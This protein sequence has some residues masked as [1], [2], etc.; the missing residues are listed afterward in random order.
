MFKRIRNWFLKTFLASKIAGGRNFYQA[1]VLFSNETDYE[2]KK[3]MRLQAISV[4]D[5]DEANLIGSTIDMNGDVHYPVIDFDIPVRLVPSSTPGHN[6]LY[7]DHPVTLQ[8]MVNMLA[9]MAEAGVVQKGFANGTR[10]NKVATVR[11]PWIQK[12]KENANG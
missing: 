2:S 5:K 7:I 6:H 10:R 3:R 8:Q 11:P 12:T 9:A 4:C 1:D